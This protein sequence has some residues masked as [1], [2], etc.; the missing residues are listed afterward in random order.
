MVPQAVDYAGVRRNILYRNPPLVDDEG[1][2]ITSDDDD[3]RVGVAELAAAELNPY[4]NIR[5]ERESATGV[6]ESQVP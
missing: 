1:Y 2:E 4:S 6:F 3:D 5:L